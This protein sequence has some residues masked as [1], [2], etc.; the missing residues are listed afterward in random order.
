MRT[1]QHSEGHRPLGLC[2]PNDVL[3]PQ[4][5]L[6]HYSRERHHVSSCSLSFCD[7]VMPGEAARDG[8]LAGSGIS[9]IF[10]P[11]CQ[12]APRTC[13]FVSCLQVLL[14]CPGLSR[15]S[16]TPSFLQGALIQRPFG[17]MGLPSGHPRSLWSGT[18]GPRSPNLVRWCGKHFHARLGPRAPLPAT[19]STGLWAPYQGVAP[20]W[21]L[22]LGSECV[23]P[24]LASLGLN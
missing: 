21:R 23:A 3:G 5:S 19:S 6:T 11:S 18:G 13:S 16:L 22:A 7:C 24:G 15:C 2:L 12:G 1:R 20:G 8:L 9:G 10:H 4:T 14:S 17:H